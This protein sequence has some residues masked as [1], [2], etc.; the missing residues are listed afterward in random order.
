METNVLSLAELLVFSH[1]ITVE[2]L[3][4]LPD[5]GVDEIVDK[6]SRT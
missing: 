1:C 5:R 3:S 4:S 6:Q 2:Q